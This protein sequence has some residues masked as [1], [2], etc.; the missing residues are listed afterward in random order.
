MQFTQVTLGKT[1]VD[2]GRYLSVGYNSNSLALGFSALSFARESSMVFRYRLQPLFGDWRETPN[3]ELQFPGLPANDY[4]LEV[5]ASDGGGQWSGQPAVFA[6]QIRRPWWRTWWFFTLLGLTPP[7]ALLLI[8]RRRNLRQQQIQQALEEAVSVRTFELAQEKARAER[9]TLRADASN[10]AKSAFLANMSHEIRTPMNG[11][12]GMA[13]PARHRAPA[14]QREYA[15]RSAVAE[16]LLDIINDILDFSKIEAGK[17]ELEAQDF[18][19]R[20]R[21]RRTPS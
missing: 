12:L 20:E 11:V 2:D 13:D 17:L 15:E 18:D 16:Y 1:R 6:F 9:E 21:S 3:G 10:Q 8:V 7:A 14:E 4:R 19:L 5:E